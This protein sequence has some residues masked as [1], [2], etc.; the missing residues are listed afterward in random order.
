MENEFLVVRLDPG[1][2]GIASLFDKRTSRQWVREGSLTAV[3]QRCVEANEGM[4]AW[5]IGQFLERRDLLEG[6]ALRQV[7]SGPYVYTYR[8]TYPQRQVGPYDTRMWLDITLR[9]GEPRILFSLRVDWREIGH[10]EGGVPHLRVRFPLAVRAPR[11]RYEVPFG[12][13]ERDLVGQEVPAQRWVDLSDADGAGVTLVNTSKYGFSLEADGAG[14]HAL[15]MTLLRASIDPDPL[16]D[17]GEH[18]IEYALVTH[19]TSWM[20]GDCMRAGE[21]LNVPLVVAS[22]GLQ[23]GDLPLARGG[24]QREPGR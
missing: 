8:W 15:S 7:H 21:E 6:G 5:V 18:V 1:S 23:E 4:T 22:C 13:V 2:G 24:D 19:G 17:L 12:A 3:L 11:A 10:A 9:Q 16:P 20:V 14:G